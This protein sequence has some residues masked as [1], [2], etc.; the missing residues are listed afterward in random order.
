MS[1]GRSALERARRRRRKRGRG[2]S[3]LSSLSCRLSLLRWAR[4]LCL[5]EGAAS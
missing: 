5:F 2:R 1:V 3:P 4:I